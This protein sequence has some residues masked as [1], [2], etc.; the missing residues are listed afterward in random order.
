MRG[1][2]VPPPQWFRSRVTTFAAALISIAALWPA[3]SA[4]AEI[5]YDETFGEDGLV[6]APFAGASAIATQGEDTLVAGGD[7]EIVIARLNPDG[8]LDPEFGVGGIIE[9]FEDFS[10]EVS[11]IEVVEDGI[12][13]AGTAAPGL[14]FAAKLVPNGYAYV[15][16][17]QFGIRTFE[18]NPAADPWR[19]AA[20]LDV[21]AEG[22][23]LL[24]GSAGSEAEN[25][26]IDAF[27]ARLTPL[28][29]LD[30]TFAGDGTA[31]TGAYT[32]PIGYR[33][34][35]DTLRSVVAMPDGNACGSG[36]VNHGNYFE[37]ATFCFAEDGSPLPV[38]TGWG[39]GSI[40]DAVG[41]PA[42]DLLQVARQMDI[43]NSYRVGRVSWLDDKLATPGAGSSE[44][45]LP[46]SVDL[47][48]EDTAIVA[49]SQS[50]PEIGKAP[51][52][53]VVD[54][55]RPEGPVDHARLELASGA[56]GEASEIATIGPTSFAA[57]VD[58]QDG[59]QP[60]SQRY[61]ARLTTAEE[62]PVKEPPPRDRGTLT[63]GELRAPR[64]LDGLVNHG[65]RIPARCS[66]DCNIRLELRASRKSVKRFDLPS[67]RLSGWQVDLAGETNNAIRFRIGNKAADRLRARRHM[68]TERLGLRVVTLSVNYSD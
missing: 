5:R 65:A 21:D 4:S 1:M 28:G 46:L 15:T 51:A 32:A 9:P 36:T 64:T 11:G 48:D 25:G 45:A 54:K 18:W 40:T 50:L 19:G 33:P 24:G 2:A 14:P 39:E 67:R 43:S 30:E 29:D 62:P 57:F 37:A 8:E 7:G 41:T 53:W 59:L 49:G 47:L 55:E 20:G 34:S 17:G 13:L 56:E 42:G 3:T 22:R 66:L 16:F 10:A 31:S 58:E 38:A 63:L 27:V 61:V 26:G 60:P 12:V 44:V 6:E 52:F 68:S 35:T 23:I